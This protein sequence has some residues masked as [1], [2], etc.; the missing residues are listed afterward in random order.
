[1]KPR[2]QHGLRAAACVTTALLLLVP[3][4]AGARRPA[5]NTST[6]QTTTVA[7]RTPA[8]PARDAAPARTDSTVTVSHTL[9]EQ[10]RKLRDLRAQIADLRKRDSELGTREK[11]TAKELRLLQQKVAVNADLLRSLVDMQDRLELQLEG[12]R[13]EHGRATEILTERKQRLARTLRAMYERGTPTTAELMLRTASV[14]YALSHFK[15]MELLARNNERLLREIRQQE[16]FLAA[17]NA[18]LTQ[19]LVELTANAQETRQEKEELATAQRAQQTALKRVRQ[20]RA[21][22]QAALA[23]LAAAEKKVQSVIAA[24]E[25]KRQAAQAAGRPAETFPDIG[26]ARL[27]GAMPWPVR[28]PV[29]TG[30]GNQTHPKYGTVTFNGGLDIAAPEGAP[31]R[32]VARGQV[33][34]AKW[35]DGYGRTIIVNHGGGYYTVYAHLSEIL[36]A[37]AQS[38]EPGTVIGRVGDTGSLD[39][40]KLHFEVWER[41][42]AVNPR[43]WLGR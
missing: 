11:N 36:V 39:G 7:Q 28:G 27:R 35:T 20:Q 40:V 41:S 31:V 14:R 38:V 2:A 10:E 4:A 37:E 42:E 24:L 1:M 8:R 34:Y 32:V 23:D 17:T 16:E 13:A 21:E 9:A 22:Y 33:E 6:R 25:K 29:M 5:R 18:R 30:F 19:T 12:I 15:Y 43:A 26:F 3:G